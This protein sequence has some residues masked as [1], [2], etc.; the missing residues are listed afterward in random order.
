M[1]SQNIPLKGRT[2][3]YLFDDWFDP[4]E[5]AVAI[6][7]SGT[8]V[9]VRMAAQMNIGFPL[10]AKYLRPSER[11]P[12]LRKRPPSEHHGVQAQ[13]L[14]QPARGGGTASSDVMGHRGSVG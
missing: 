4:I 5:A 2:A 13:G 12:M 1:S 3:V 8:Q 11:N 9:D 7:K 6:T 10:S 14:A